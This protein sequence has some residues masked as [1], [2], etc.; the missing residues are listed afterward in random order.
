MQVIAVL[1]QKAARENDCHDP[2]SQGTLARWCGCSSGR[3]ESSR[4][5]AHVIVLHGRQTIERT[6]NICCLGA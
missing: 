3:F 4:V 2:P 1:N 5:C 6:L